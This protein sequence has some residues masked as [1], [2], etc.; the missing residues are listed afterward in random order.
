[1]AARKPMLSPLSQLQGVLTVLDNRA[2]RPTPEVLAAVGSLVR[3][4]IAVMQ[5][6]DPFRRRVGFVLLAIQ[7][8]TEV[9][10]F[11]RNGK[12]LTRVR[13]VDLDLYNWAMAEAHVLAGWAK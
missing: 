8:S 4:A 1:M 11:V 9:R 13:V 10:Q 3:D 5:E 7:E 6:P 2:K 12:T